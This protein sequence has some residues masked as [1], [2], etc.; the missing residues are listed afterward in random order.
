MHFFTFTNKNSK[1]D[2]T[3]TKNSNNINIK[4]PKIVNNIISDEEKKK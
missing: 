2:E 4:K 1:I 3:I